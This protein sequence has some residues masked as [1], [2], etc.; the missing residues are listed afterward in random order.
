MFSAQSKLCF[1][2]DW[3]SGKDFL[4]DTADKI[5]ELVCFQKVG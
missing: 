5:M 1:V 4:V 2:R 3:L